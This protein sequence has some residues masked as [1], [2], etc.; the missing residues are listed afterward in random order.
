M[1]S[2]DAL[3]AACQHQVLAVLSGK[4]LPV[5]CPTRGFSTI[6]ETTGVSPKH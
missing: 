5:L 6:G 1:W 4:Y 2:E 3:A